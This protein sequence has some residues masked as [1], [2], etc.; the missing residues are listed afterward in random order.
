MKTSVKLLG[1][2][3]FASVT[4]AWGQGSVAWLWNQTNFEVAPADQIFLAGTITNY[5][6]SPYVIPANAGA[7]AFWG[8]LQPYYSIFFHLDFHDKTVPGNGSLHFTFGTL[9]PIGGFVPPGNYPGNNAWIDLTGNGGQFPLNTF[10]V[11]VTPEPVLPNLFAG[12]L[13]ALLFRS[14]FRH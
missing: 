5:S 10:Q 13:A 4:S 6:T 3:T 2:L 1:L 11:K 14:R 7:A 8:E 9:T 12:G